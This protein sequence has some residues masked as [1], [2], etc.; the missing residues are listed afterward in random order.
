MG[1]YT[2]VIIYICR[3]L[4]LMD[5]KNFF[6]MRLGEQLSNFQ[7]LITPPSPWPDLER[8]LFKSLLVRRK[9]VNDLKLKYHGASTNQTLQGKVCGSCQRGH[10]KLFD[11]SSYS[12]QIRDP[13]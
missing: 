7:I 8:A 2:H 3:S 11:L 1:L 6:A 10:E 13:H 12:L 9:Y 5:E 4:L